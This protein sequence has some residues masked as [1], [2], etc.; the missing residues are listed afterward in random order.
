MSGV[1]EQYLDRCPECGKIPP[2][3]SLTKTSNGIYM[4]LHTKNY[5]RPEMKNTIMFA[6]FRQ[7]ECVDDVESSIDYALCHS[8]VTRIS[9]ESFIKE[10]IKR[11]KQIERKGRVD[12]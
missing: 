1:D 5:P 11:A 7:M 4:W 10:L 12:L 9:D 2:V 6:A 3:W 8:C